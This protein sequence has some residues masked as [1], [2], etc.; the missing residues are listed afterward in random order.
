MRVEEQHAHV[1]AVDEPPHRLREVEADADGPGYDKEAGADWVKVLQMY[2]IEELVVLP[3][4]ARQ[5][6]SP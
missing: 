1:R 2:K 4:E 6:P 5:E 3:P